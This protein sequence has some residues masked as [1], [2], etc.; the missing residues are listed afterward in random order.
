[1]ISI[2]KHKNKIM[3]ESQTSKWT[4]VLCNDKRSSSATFRIQLFLGGAIDDPLKK[5]N[6]TK[7]VT[8]RHFQHLYTF[9]SGQEKVADL[10]AECNIGL[11]A[12]ETWQYLVIGYY[13][14]ARN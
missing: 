12:L 13:E 1:M 10:M 11:L 4:I 9:G 5:F 2:N 8:E 3:Q 7:I 6:I 14:R